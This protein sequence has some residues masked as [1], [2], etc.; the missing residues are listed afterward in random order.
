MG[1][2]PVAEAPAPGGGDLVLYRR[3]GEFMIRAGG[4]ELMSSRAHG[5]EE[6]LARLACARLAAKGEACVLVGGLG[7][8]Y[9]LRA[10]LDLLPGDA[11]VRVAE[12]SPAVAAW[13]RGPLAHLAGN[14]LADGRVTLHLTDVA[15]VLA[16]A[17]A[18]FDAILLDVDNGPGNLM[19][20]G[21]AALY[22]VQGL[23]AVKRALKQGGTFAVWSAAPAPGFA[24][25]LREAGF[26][27]GRHRVAARGAKGDPEHTIY[28]GVL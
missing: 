16:D 4:L 12:I 15:E 21:N 14:P 20:P 22:G 7:L 8:G 1:W 9:T 26:R 24:R 3:G 5:S 25:R 18:A 19:H 6:A 28:L 10:V 17:D 2:E 11:R 13:N 27:V 23:A